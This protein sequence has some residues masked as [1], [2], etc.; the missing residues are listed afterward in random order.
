MKKGQ[1]EQSSRFSI[2]LSKTQF[3]TVS[4]VNTDGITQYP[5]LLGC[6][7]VNYNLPL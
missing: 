2:D 5:K 7:E 1:K 3:F 4:V 6:F